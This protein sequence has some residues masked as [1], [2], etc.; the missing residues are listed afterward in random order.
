MVFF[1][2][3]VVFFFFWGGGHFLW[4]SK[5]FLSVLIKFGVILADNGTLLG[6]F[7]WSFLGG[8]KRF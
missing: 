1:L 4:F 3:V 8:I 5:F 2:T 6:G 7:D